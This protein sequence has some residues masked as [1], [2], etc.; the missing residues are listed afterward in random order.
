[1]PASTAP[2]A[3]VREQHSRTPA[4]PPLLAP[5][6]ELT[7]L[8]RRTSGAS[9]VRLRWSVSAAAVAAALPACRAMGS[10]GTAILEL[11]SMRPSASDGPVPRSHSAAQVLGGNGRPWI[12]LAGEPALGGHAPGEPAWL[13]DPETGL[14]HVDVPGLLHAT[15]R[16]AAGAKPAPLIETATGT[17]PAGLPLCVLYARTTLFEL[18]GVRGGRYELIGGDLCGPVA[19]PA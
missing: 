17:L 16:A 1:M 5:M 18:I 8:A 15:Y 4:A 2:S 9:L 6:D 13:T 14:D 10:E 7:A 12:D 11:I 3:N 19:R